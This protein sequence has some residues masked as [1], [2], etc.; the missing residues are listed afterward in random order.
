MREDAPIACSLNA[1]ELK[2]RLATIAEVGAHSL[3]S[4]DSVGDRHQLR[5]RADRTTHQKLEEIISAEGEC[6]KFLNL[7]L[8]EE[9]GELVMWIAAPKDAELLAAEFANAFSEAPSA[10]VPA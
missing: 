7:S 10:E 9:K 3:I 5:F 4:Q 2:A 1:G 6:C 8:V